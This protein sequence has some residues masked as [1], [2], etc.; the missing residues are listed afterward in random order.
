[1]E[2]AS[3]SPRSS[4]FVQNSA[5]P[6]T[7]PVPESELQNVIGTK[8]KSSVGRSKAGKSQCMLEILDTAGTEQFTAMRDLYMKNGN[9]FVIMYSILSKST[10][11]DAVGM[12]EMIQRIRDED[13]PSVVL[14]ANKIDLDDQRV[15]SKQEGEQSTVA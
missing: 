14:V 4:L 13:N 12:Y 1:M 10:Y 7:E 5:S 9:G 15:V 3:R 8:P 6:L 2:T 11:N